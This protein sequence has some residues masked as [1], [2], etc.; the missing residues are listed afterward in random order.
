MY[1]KSQD[2]LRLNITL[3]LSIKKITYNM[4][5]CLPTVRTD[6]KEAIT[7]K[8]INSLSYTKWNC[9]YHIVCVYALYNKKTYKP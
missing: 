4:F 8:D 1:R 6:T 7:M 2:S 5:C 3:V 9:K